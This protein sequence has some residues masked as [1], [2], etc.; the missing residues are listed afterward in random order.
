MK[1]W[2][3]NK[4]QHIEVEIENEIYFDATSNHD[5]DMI[6]DVIGKKAVVITRLNGVMDY[7]YIGKTYPGFNASD[8]GTKQEC[9]ELLT[10]W[11][12]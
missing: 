10:Q 3:E 11:Y 2:N 1:T 4:K 6:A 7:V 8:F 9:F 5:I 12:N